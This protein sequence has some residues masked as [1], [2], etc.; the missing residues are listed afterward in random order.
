MSTPSTATATLPPH[1]QYYP[2]HQSWQP[3]VS[4][5][6]NG[7]SRLTNSH[8]NNQYPSQDLRRT[9][10]VNA[11][12]PQP[13]ES[14]PTHYTADQQQL[15][16]MPSRRR[17]HKPDW[18]E[19][20]KN[21]I[22]KEVIVIDDDSPEPQASRAVAAEAADRHADKKRKTAT[23]TAYDPVYHQNTSYSTTE[24]PIYAETPS[25]HTI[26]TDRTASA[27]HTTASTSL[28]S[29][30]SN[31][32]YA[33]QL[34]DGVVG[35]K[36]KR[37]TRRT[38]LDEAKEAKRRET[39]QQQEHWT[40]YIPPKQPPIKAKDVYVKVVSDVSICCPLHTRVSADGL[41]K[42]RPNEKVDDEDGHYVVHPDADITEKCKCTL[43]TWPCKT[44]MAID[45]IVKLLGQG[46]F[47]KVVEAFDKKKGNKVAIKVIR[48]VQKY[49]DASRIELRVLSTLASNDPHNRNK[50]IHL[51]DCFDFRNHIC[52]VTDLYGQSV[53]DFLKS[54]QF[55]PFPS[56][57]IQTFAHQLLTSVA[58]KSFLEVFYLPLKFHTLTNHSS[59]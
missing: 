27:L 34:E 49:R 56:T 55:V 18:N 44:L 58:C 29:T 39:E 26:S 57:H 6:V 17:G 31:G 36:R 24:T 14:Y 35:Q 45:Q 50:C 5:H 7:S 4:Q 19:F 1:H 42:Y 48:S 16:N 52:I 38:T 51:R 53:F 22:P 8:Y 47:G 28:G 2:H 25:N 9:A 30:I 3:Q 15:S 21:G 41:Q 40:T 32:A 10:T 12:Q 54:N 11:R 23:S 13:A 46:T 33:A 43:Y 37:T 59:S 20:Y